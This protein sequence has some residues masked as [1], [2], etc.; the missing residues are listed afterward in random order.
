MEIERQI[1]PR[2]TFRELK[3]APDEDNY[4]SI[5]KLLELPEPELWHVRAFLYNIIGLNENFKGD[6]Y[7]YFNENKKMHLRVLS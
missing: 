5:N 1:N 2:S 3:D 7:L 6:G 4:I